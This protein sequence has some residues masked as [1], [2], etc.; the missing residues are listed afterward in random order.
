MKDCTGALLFLFNFIFII[1]YSANAQVDWKI[2]SEAGISGSDYNFSAKPDDII[3]RVDGNLQYL[4]LQD[5]YSAS[6]KFRVR[7][8]I[9]GLSNKFS[10]LKFKFSGDYYR[11]EKF[12]N[13][14]IDLNMQKNLYQTESA[15][16]NYDI[17]SLSVS[18]DWSN[19]ENH[20]ISIQLGYAYQIVS[21][22]VK[23]DL[24]LL[25]FDGKIF[26]SLFNHN[27]LG[28]GLYL[29]KFTVGNNYLNS[30]R[31]F[32]NTNSGWRIGPQIS[33][34]Y[35]DEEV[36]R[37]EYR[38]LI[39]SSRLTKYPSYE[40]RIRFIAGKIFWDD[41]S[42]FLLADYYDRHFAFRDD[43]L[44]ETNLIYNPLDIENKIN[45]KIAYEIS[46][47]FEIYLK[48]GYFKENFFDQKYN[49]DGWNAL[50]GIEICN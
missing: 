12:V 6:V 15:D 25:I 21:E 37:L 42:I 20:P 27:N 2:N 40:H 50:L 46:S 22:K 41:W 24:D 4:Y 36:L 30:S 9:Y 5:D 44:A 26:S 1:I 49:F 33:F 43:K 34:E 11:T 8:E 18:T 39:H 45:I 7:P 17:F 28:C 16:F 47:T 29:E 32:E 19:L 13:W 31:S 38:F 23:Q 14:G 3:F 10:S 35:Q 48:S